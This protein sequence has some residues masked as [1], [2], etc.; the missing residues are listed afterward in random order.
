MA[1]ARA[2]P[3][4]VGGGSRRAGLAVRRSFFVLGTGARARVR[5][6]LPRHSPCVALS[7]GAWRGRAWSVLRVPGAVARAGSSQLPLLA[8]PGCDWPSSGGGRHVCWAGPSPLF[9]LGPRGRPWGAFPRGRGASPGMEIRMV[10]WAGDG[11]RAVRCVRLLALSRGGALAAGLLGVRG[12]RRGG[13]PE[14]GSGVPGVAGPPWCVAVGSRVRF[15]GG[16]GFCG[17]R[18]SLRPLPRASGASPSVALVRPP[19]PLAVA[20]GWAVRPPPS[21]GGWAL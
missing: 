7:A 6:C 16:S 18:R 15:P 20:A 19:P 8:T 13:S 10:G 14:A 9:P 12:R 21:G 5:A 3:L 4:R 1:A 11:A 17:P 2:S